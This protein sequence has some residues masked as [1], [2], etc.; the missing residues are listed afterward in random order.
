MEL[1]HC[2]QTVARLLKDSATL[3]LNS[4]KGLM[5]NA[6]QLTANIVAGMPRDNDTM[7]T[8]VYQI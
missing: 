6:E 3:G 7:L 4:R 5:I 1:F 2:F 8:K